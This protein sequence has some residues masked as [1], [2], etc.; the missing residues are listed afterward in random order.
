[1]TTDQ[2]LGA[3]IRDGDRTGLRY[4]RTLRHPPERVWQALTQSQHLASW[5]PADLVGERRAGATI[6]VRF[7]P[8]IVAKYGIED[9]SLPGRILV[10]N[11]PRVLEWTWDVD[12][13]R[14]EL[15]PL[16]DGTELTFTTWLGES[17]AEGDGD[18]DLVPTAAGYHLCLD[19][20][21][22]LLDGEQPAPIAHAD[23]VP[24]EARYREGL[25]V[26]DRHGR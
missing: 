17:D 19:H 5:M 16:S 7:W 3:V 20:L 14:W 25:G 10:W 22:A 12:L 8:E 6:A 23:P 11:P 9:P 18:G 2:P 21:I 26:Q 15:E 24:V 4:L 13:L 1:M